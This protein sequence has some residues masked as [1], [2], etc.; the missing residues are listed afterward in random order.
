MTAL[1][2]LVCCMKN[3]CTYNGRKQVC[4]SNFHA[5]ILFITQSKFDELLP[6][7]VTLLFAAY[8]FIVLIKRQN[9]IIVL[10]LYAKT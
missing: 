7:L 5:F 2:T 9:N 4:M 6:N 1:S 10:K 8:S 3:G